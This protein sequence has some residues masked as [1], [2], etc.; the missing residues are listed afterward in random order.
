MAEQQVARGSGSAYDEASRTLAE[1]SEAYALHA[2]RDTFSQKLKRFM[3]G[4]M[5]RKTLVQRLVKAGIWHE[6]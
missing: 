3:A 6:K 1:I 5:R 2:S 4:R